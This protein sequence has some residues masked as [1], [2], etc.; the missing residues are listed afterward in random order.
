M[1]CQAERG[2][3]PGFSLPRLR[4]LMQRSIAATELD[5]RGLTILTEAA[6]GAYATTAIIAAMAGAGRVYA[7]T[8]PSRFGSV[9]QVE[10]S[11]YRLATY[12]GVADQVTM[13]EIVSDS[14]IREAD[15]VTNCGHLRPLRAELINLLPHHA[16]IALMFE[17]WEFRTEDLDLDACNRRGI[18]VVGVN[19]RHPAID[20]FS[21]LGPLCVNQLHECGLAVHGDR[22]ALLC[23]NPFAQSIVHGLEAAGANI[24]T[25][26]SVRE[27]YRDGWD[28]IVVA[29]RPTS[30]SRVCESDAAYISSVAPAGTPLVQFWGDVDRQAALA[31]GLTVWPPR[32]PDKGHMGVMLSDIGPEPIV[33]LQTGGLKAAEWVFRGGGET[34]NGFSQ[35]VRPLR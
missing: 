11:M 26:S 4:T 12:M 28:A 10:A 31:H 15:I 29:M 27:L 14:I 34:P 35:F 9:P 3:K 33:R 5:L 30:S 18:R 8:R 19:E 22:L 25:F 1:N 24:Q 32:E 2:E 16:I 6:T 17:A 21:F 13:I 23:D 20:V 7:F